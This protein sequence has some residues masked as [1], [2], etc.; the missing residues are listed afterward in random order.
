MEEDRR[1]AVV[2]PE[3][4]TVGQWW[5]DIDLVKYEEPGRVSAT[6]GEARLMRAI[7]MD[8]SVSMDGPRRMR[9]TALDDLCQSVEDV[10]RAALL[11][12]LHGEQGPKYSPPLR[13]LP[14]DD[15][16]YLTAMGWLVEASPNQSQMLVL[17][18]RAATPPVTYEFIGNL[19]R[20]SAARAQQIY[21]A[22]V[23][24]AVAA[25]NGSM[26]RSRQRVAAVQER[27]REARR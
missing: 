16:D 17:M 26:P 6:H 11:E 18:A 20:T 19:I 12:V 15:K 24:R 10:L 3:P 1:A 23:A 22:T 7:A 13:C 25:A 9:S 8:R 2:E 21:E 27:N 4:V 14:Q 5:R